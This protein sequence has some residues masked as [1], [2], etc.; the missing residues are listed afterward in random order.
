MEGRGYRESIADEIAVLSARDIEDPEVEA[1]LERANSLHDEA[2]RALENDEEEKSSE[3]Y[4]QVDR[5]ITRLRSAEKMDKGPY[6]NEGL[7]QVYE[8]PDL[9]VTWE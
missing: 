4:R 1:L 8:E 9:P 5:N 7:P 3:L 6:W 2:V